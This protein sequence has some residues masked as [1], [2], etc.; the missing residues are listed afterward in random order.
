[1]GPGSYA[2]MLYAS[3]KAATILLHACHLLVL[4]AAIHI[5]WIAFV[6]G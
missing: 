4:T 1:M 2:Y 3:Y 6:H 5:A